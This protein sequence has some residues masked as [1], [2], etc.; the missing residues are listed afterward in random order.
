MADVTYNNIVSPRLAN[1][2]FENISDGVILVDSDGRINYVNSAAENIFDVKSEEVVDKGFREVFMRNKKNSD[3]NILMDN[4]M[5]KGLPSEKEY[6]EYRTESGKKTHLAVDVSL[7]AESHV[8]RRVP[9]KGMMI[10]V[11]DETIKHQ[12]KQQARDSAY[13]IAGLITCITVYLS[14]WS[15]FRFTLGRPYTNAFYT[16]LIEGISFILFLEVFFFTS[17]KFSEIGMVP[18]I[19]RIKKNTVE[20]L[21]LTI[22]GSSLLIISRGGQVFMELGG[23]DYFI[24]GTLSGFLSY[25]AT[26]ITQEFL[27]R[28]VIQTSVKAVFQVKWQRPL[29][30][31]MTS[32]LFSLMHIPF[33][34]AFMGAA[35]L[36]SLVLGIIFEV[37]E[38]IWGCFI[39]HWVIGYIAMCLFF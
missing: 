4:T 28:G 3:F 27:A 1:N 16:R 11:E 13:I 35:F 31:L 2:L 6:L 26:A 23:K 14:L 25:A 18:N 9:F 15:L 33:G 36:L 29:A 10:L 30:V 7:V 39:L 32:L 5:S 34:F 12:L 37:Q 19:P 38:D 24:G 17:I 22:L 20:T 21:L 8:F